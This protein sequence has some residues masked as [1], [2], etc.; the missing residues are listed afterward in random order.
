LETLWNDIRFGLKT[1]MRSP[2]TTAVA[3]LTLALGIGA[4]SAIFSVVSGVL[5]E[6]LAI[7]QADR[8]VLVWESNPKAG[9]PRFGVSPLNYEDWKQRT[10]AFSDMVALSEHSFSVTGG[11]RPEMITG[12]RVS[13]DFFRV[14]GV[15]PVVG[16]SF[17]AAEDRPGAPRVTVIS[18]GLWQRR[19]GSDR[20]VLDRSILLD[21]VPHTI[22]GVMPR[23]FD[24]Y[25]RQ[26]LWVPLVLHA[27]PVTRN[28][29]YLATLGRLKPGVSMDRARA[30][31]KGVAEQLA[32]EYPDTNAGW[33][34]ELISFP[35]SLVEDIRPR[36]LLLLWAVAFVLLIACANVA[37]LLLARVAAREREIAVRAALGA[38]RGRLVRQ[39]LTENV[40]LFLAGGGLGLLVGVWITRS[41]IALNPDG[42]PRS[43]DI[44]LD[45][46]VLLFTFG[47]SLLTGLVFGLLPAL[48]ATGS[49]L[50]TVLKEGG[51]GM[52]GGAQGRLVRSGLVLAEVAVALVLLVGAALLIRSFSGLLS[53]DPG[54]RPGGVLTAQ[55]QLPEFKYPDPQ[56]RKLFYRALME[57]AE[58]LPGVSA[59]GAIYPLPLLGRDMVFAFVVQGRPIPR[60]NE[61]PNASVWAVTPG[62]F[63]AMGVPLLAG[64]GFAP[65]DNEN[66]IPVAIINKTMADEVWPGESPLGKQFSVDD[67][68]QAR[69]SWL[70][71][72]GVAGDV[73]HRGL[74]QDSGYEFY[75]PL[76][77]R[78]VSDISLIVRRANDQDPAALA[79]PVRDLVAQLDPD[80]PVDQVQPM[81]DVVR[82]ALSQSRFQTVLLGLFAALALALAAIGVY[83]V[84][85]YS[86]A[87]RTHEIGIRM[88]LGAQR[89]QVLRL[90]V[91]QGMAVVALGVGLGLVLSFVLS[92]VLADRAATFLYGV[93]ATDPLTLLAV[94]LVLLAVAL[95]AN[96]LPARRATK[97][98][99]L[100][101]LRTD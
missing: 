69:V 29:H 101:A 53:V 86:V 96:F 54:L 92:R 43:A 45:A 95:L 62:Y 71:V 8:L 75:W 7:P 12:A 18:Y 9:L 47:L 27:E 44:G 38:G 46:R 3:L 37:N 49:R 60:P 13:G 61:A 87:Q 5:L 4:N 64:R 74:N 98:D 40:L 89:A 73:R 31:L 32:A 72:I 67:P 63:R 85:S 50:H 30:D 26:D 33:T 39:M 57:R 51:R 17:R 11:E 42:I 93:S 76:E 91:S 78:P 22:I 10:R 84:V 20:A 36:L 58:A 16:R 34:V 35:D 59:A 81:T 99:P 65:E 21:G 94:P 70:T 55:L 25:R 83:G 77:Q 66:G 2:A 56:Q 23:G 14:L 100:V 97:V 41:L 88:A 24:F 68:R 80:L 6:P 1:W 19:F 52:A 90:I 15:E 79:R 48:N 82:G 28:Q